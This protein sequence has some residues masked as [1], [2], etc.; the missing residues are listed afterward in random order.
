MPNNLN[1]EKHPKVTCLCP[2][3]G[4]FTALRE[5]ISFFLLQDYPNKELLIFN[6]HK[7]P[8]Q[9]HPK[10]INQGV[11]VI[12]GGDYSE[13]DLPT[14]YNDAMSH[15]SEDTVYVAIW[16]DD[17]IYFPWHLSASIKAIKKSSKKASRVLRS[18]YGVLE[19]P[20]YKICK[21]SP[22]IE[23]LFQSNNF[24][25]SM[26]V[27]K[28]LAQFKPLPWRTAKEEKEDPA[29]IHP[30]IHWNRL[31]Q[32]HHGGFEVLEDPTC[33][34][35]FDSI[36]WRYPHT[37]CGARGSDDTGEGETLRPCSVSKEIYDVVAKSK[38]IWGE[39]DRYNLI[40]KEDQAALLKRF[41]DYEIEKFDHIDKYKVWFYWENVHTD[42]TPDF[43]KMCHYS[44]RLH[45]YADVV[46]LNNE[47]LEEYFKAD[48]IYPNDKFY[49]FSCICYKSDYVR[50]FILKHYGG[51]WM[52][53]DVLSVGT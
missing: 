29:G 26:V 46:V 22:E 52:D 39:G 45:T 18:F 28:Q 40:S 11:R 3:A 48:N 10:L 1:L 8:L 43:V 31:V 23:Y 21:Q 6:N 51:F 33:A 19:N 47:I 13:K 30:H 14:I 25:A 5:S 15:V 16:D 7:E 36:G 17:D 50:A 53:S 20:N 32:D 35:R 37:Q 49:N 44:A 27:E 34:F 42:N 41:N 9:P 38:T 2:T 12:N 4:R 24:E